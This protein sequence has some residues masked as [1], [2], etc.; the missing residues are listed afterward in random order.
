M[1]YNWCPRVSYH[2]VGRLQEKVGHKVVDKLQTSQHGQGKLRG[3][4]IL[5]RI[6]LCRLESCSTATTEEEPLAVLLMK[7]VE[8]IGKL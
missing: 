5:L 3:L 8:E 6:E 4:K 7:N 2:A 1:I